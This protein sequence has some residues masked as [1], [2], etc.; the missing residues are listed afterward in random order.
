MFQKA[1]PTQAVTNPVS[2]PSVLLYVQ[3]T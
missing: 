2:L 3:Y 1:V